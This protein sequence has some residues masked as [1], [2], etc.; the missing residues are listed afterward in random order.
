MPFLNT[1]KCQKC[2]QEKP[3]TSEYFYKNIKRKSGLET[4]CKNCRIELKK[5]WR[6][7]PRGIKCQRK[8][9]RDFYS[10]NRE[11]I[12]QKSKE[13]RKNN[14]EKYKKESKIL[15][16]KRINKGLG[17]IKLR[18]E[19]LLRDNFTCQYCGR[20]SP[21]VILEV[22]H[23]FPRAKGGELLN[24]DNLITACFECNRGKGD[25]LIKNL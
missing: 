17:W 12:L 2:N 4:I 5:R 14:P 22:D 9:G 13:D 25:C 1:M 8:S 16:E 15:K 24:K 7:T 11:K 10:R 19:I 6:K 20:K 21:E 3:H 18:F 23:I